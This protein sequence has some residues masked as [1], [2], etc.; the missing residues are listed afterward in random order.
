M[1]EVDTTLTNIAP[2]LMVKTN[3]A[4]KFK[5]SIVSHDLSNSIIFGVNLYDAN[6]VLIDV[7]YV[8]LTGTDY[9]NNINVSGLITTIAQQLE[10]TMQ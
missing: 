9:T 10:L 4:T 5:A 3:T 8:T 2:K 6:D 7:Q 1:E